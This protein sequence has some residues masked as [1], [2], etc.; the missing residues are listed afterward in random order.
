MTLTRDYIATEPPT[1]RYCLKRIHFVPIAEHEYKCPAR[2]AG[3]EPH[4]VQT[5]AFAA[6]VQRA[7]GQKGGAK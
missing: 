2:M 3:V 6:H 5:V 4:D 7:L 1:C